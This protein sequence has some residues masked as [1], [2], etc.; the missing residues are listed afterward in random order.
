VTVTLLP[1]VAVNAPP[2]VLTKPAPRLTMTLPFVLRNAPWVT[3]R[4]PLPLVA[5]VR[6]PA[7]AVP[8]LTSLA[9]FTVIAAPAV[10]SLRLKLRPAEDVPRVTAPL[11]LMKTSLAAVAVMDARVVRNGVP[12]LPTE[13]LVELKAPEV[14]VTM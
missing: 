11:L 9:A 2:L 3:T 4:L 14:A 6:S 12:L 1:A 7:T 8:A 13:P 10:K 5:K